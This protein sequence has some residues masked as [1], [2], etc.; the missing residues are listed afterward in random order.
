MLKSNRTY[1][2]YSFG[3]Q[4]YSLHSTCKNSSSLSL[5]RVTL[6]CFGSIF[7]RVSVSFLCSL[8]GLIEPSH[9]LSPVPGPEPLPTYF[10][11]NLKR[12]TPITLVFPHLY[13]V[14]SLLC[15]GL[16]IK[17]CLT[18]ATLW[19][20]AHHAPLSMAFPR[21]ENWNGLPFP[22]PRDH[23]NP[24]IEPGSPAL[25][26]DSCLAGRFFT[27]WATREILPYAFHHLCVHACVL[28]HFSCVWLF[29]TLWT[30]AFQ[31]PLSMRFSGQEY[32][33]GLP[34]PSPGDLPDPGIEPTS[35]LSP[36]LAGGFFTTS[37]NWEVHSI[38][39]VCLILWCIC[40][41]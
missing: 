32:W 25:Q 16:V 39:H 38:T 35:L 29:K 19:T 31:S 8:V 11:I 17:S 4:W 2:L 28:N 14:F 15:G 40:L 33:S 1:L 20:V 18:L 6:P 7:L 27:N 23:P 5:L 9:C 13:F 26:V 24:G 34:L 37:T 21:Q 10:T 3:S 30:I 36:A 41:T 12:C 22:S